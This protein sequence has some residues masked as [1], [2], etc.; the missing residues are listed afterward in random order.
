VLAPHHWHDVPGVI[1][2]DC[3]VGHRVAL[4]CGKRLPWRPRQRYSNL[5]PGLR[6]V[7]KIRH[8]TRP[9]LGVMSPASADP[10]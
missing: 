7:M 1:N 2:G 6:A 8:L 9:L 10:V 4:R 3:G 5:A